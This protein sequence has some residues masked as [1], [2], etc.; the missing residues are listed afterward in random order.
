[1]NRSSKLKAVPL[2]YLGESDSCG[3]VTEPD[4]Q[5]AGPFDSQPVQAFHSS[6]NLHAMKHVVGSLVI[7]IIEQANDSEFGLEANDVCH[8]QR[9]P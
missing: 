2:R 8:Y 5:M 4:Y 7:Q 1:V 9:V 3:T 6:Q